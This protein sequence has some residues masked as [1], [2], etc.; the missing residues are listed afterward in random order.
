VIIGRLHPAD[1]D[2][3]SMKLA[4]DL[5]ERPRILVI[6]L[7]RIGDVLLTTPLVHTLRRGIP[8]ATIDM[9]VFAGTE[10]ILQ[11]N[12]DINGVITA[13]PRSSLGDTLALMRRIF[14]RY[15]LAMS[16]QA[17]DRPAFLAFAAAPRRVGLVPVDA[18]HAWW[19]RTIFHGALPVVASN[20]RVIEVLRLATWLALEPHPR[21]VCPAGALPQGAARSGPHAVVHAGPMFRYRRWTDEGWRLLA[22]ALADRGLAVAATGSPDAAE[23]E[24]LDRIWGQADV[25]V[26]RL[27]GR[28]A[29]PEIAALLSSAR[30]YVGPDTSVT[31]LAAAMGCPTVALFGPTDPRLWGPWPA[32]GLDEP[33]SAAGTIQQRGN[34]FLVQHAF[35]CTPCQREGCERH[36]DS[37]SAC[38]DKLSVDEVLAAVDQ[39]LVFRTQ[40]N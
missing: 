30:V 10:G 2:I 34:V 28:L 17:G 25:A 19:K 27:D 39:A 5:P 15:D 20:H 40:Q 16:T 14:R 36:L 38:L 26:E 33:W 4:F 32:I 37:A 31:H 22:R 1:R 7:R 6:T 11:G 12:S 29:W 18:R 8:Q 24:Y 35:P 13:P 21:I 23:R 3:D 9:L